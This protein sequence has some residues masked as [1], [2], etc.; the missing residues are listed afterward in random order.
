MS[1][2]TKEPQR[3]RNRNRGNRNRNRSRNSSTESS[4]PR[5]SSSSNRP[6]SQHQQFVKK[7]TQKLSFWQKLLKMIGL[8]REPKA[9]AKRP[10]LGNRRNEASTTSQAPKSNVR[11]N[12]GKSED[13]RESD[14]SGERNSRAGRD[15]RPP[16]ANNEVDSTRLYIGNLSYDASEHDIED[17]FK[18]VGPVRSVEV[19]YNKHTH[20]S[21]GYGFVEMLHIDEAKRA[22]EIL[23]DQPFMGRKLIV[24]GAKAKNIEEEHAARQASAP[25]REDRPARVKQEDAAAVTAKAP[26]ASVAA[27]VSDQSLPTIAVVEEVTSLA[28][29]V[30]APICATETVQQSTETAVAE[31]SAEPVAAVVTT[32]ETSVTHVEMAQVTDVVIPSSLSSAESNSS[33]Q[34]AENAPAAI[35]INEVVETVAA[36]PITIEVPSGFAPSE[37]SAPIAETPSSDDTPLAALN[38]SGDMPAATEEKT[39]IEEVHQL[40]PAAAEQPLN[41]QPQA[42]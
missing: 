42:H 5:N 35:V 25:R 37:P 21:K 22:V 13:A 8:Y 30:D 39:V 34:S 7:A 9:A 24:S 12:R 23:H 26:S 33:T 15:R 41:D 18:G 38:V 31:E 2:G 32:T 1:N 36:A 14:G 28:A 20:K 29:E 11:G 6:P 19:V 3:S 10:E 27:S 17:L 4:S 16:V 40:A